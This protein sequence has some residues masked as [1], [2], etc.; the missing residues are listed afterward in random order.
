M[1]KLTHPS[2]FEHRRS[3]G[4]SGIARRTVTLMAVLGA[5]VAVMG[6]QSDSHPQTSLNLQVPAT[7]SSSD[8]GFSSSASSDAVA[9]VNEASVVPTTP[10]FAEM[11]Q[12]GGGQ[13]K[14]YGRP[15]YRG[16]NTN[17]D[18]SSKWIFF[19]GAGLSQP[20]G[21]TW[22]YLTPSY[23]FQVGG[24]RQFSKRFAVPIQFDYDNFG[25]TAQTLNNQTTIYDA[26]FGAGSVDGILDGNSHVWSIT[27]DPTFTFYSGDTW[28]AYG[29]VGAG[30][31]HKTAAFTVPS[32][33][34]YC[35]PYYGCY[36]Y[37]ANA[38]IDKY[39]SN[40]PGFD[41]GFGITYKFSRF[42]NERL[43]AEARYV[44]VDNSQK[45]GI[46]VN[47]LSTVTATTTNFYPANSN[48]TTLIPIKVGIRF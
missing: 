14:R 38:P 47:N 25:M 19:A 9:P 28:G 12:Y 31:Y 34:Q 33:Q 39:T 44:F 16:N 15:R 36:Q 21:N 6:A 30:Y 3:G 5:G 29:V 41:G 20:I 7:L 17:A 26:L 32:T 45:T 2:A 35:D 10:N 13:R 27:V 43:Y 37:Q 40:A 4:L 1:F 22:H 11:M 42:A 46:T 24:G 23:G 8:A 18:G 48:R